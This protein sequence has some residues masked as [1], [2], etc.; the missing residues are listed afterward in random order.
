LQLA[1]QKLLV[2]VILFPAMLYSHLQDYLLLFLL[3]MPLYKERKITS[4]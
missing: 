2:I 1:L 3:F 4:I